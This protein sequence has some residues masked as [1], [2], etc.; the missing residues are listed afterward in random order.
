V[1]LP[2]L[3]LLLLLLPLL[4]LPGLGRRLGDSCRGTLEVEGTQSAGQ[5]AGGRGGGRGEGLAGRKLACAHVPVTTDYTV[6]L[7][8]AAT[9]RGTSTLLLARFSLGFDSPSASSPPSSSSCVHLAR[10]QKKKERRRRRKGERKGGKNRDE[11]S[12][13]VRVS[14]CAADVPCLSLARARSRSLSSL[15]LSRFVN[16]TICFRYSGLCSIR[17]CRQQRPIT[18]S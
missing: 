15:S 13:A 16:F 17:L 2:L 8:R 5:G 9:H 7:H 14:P 11:E 3:L 10:A 6:L 4:L 1:L 18:G 12:D